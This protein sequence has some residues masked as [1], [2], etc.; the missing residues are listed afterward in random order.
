MKLNAKQTPI[1]LILI[2]ALVGM[3][4]VANAFYDPGLQRWINRDPIWEEG[5]V[6]LYA[7]TGNEPVNGVD[8]LGLWNTCGHNSLLNSA[9]GKNESLKDDLKQWK[10]ASKDMDKKRGA[11]NPENS[12]QHGM[13][14]P[15]K[16]KSDERQRASDFIND[17]L[18]KAI[19]A[20]RQGD[21]KKAM[22]ELGRGMHTIADRSSP[23]HKGEQ[24]WRGLKNPLFWP[25][26]G[27]HALQ[28]LWPNR[29]QR[30]EVV[31]NL[32]D[33]YQQFQDGCYYQWRE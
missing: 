14:D 21:H 9:F 22:D 33:Y 17:Q 6:N 11:Q 19:T 25:H 15:V 23:A 16:N 7:P 10:N 3:V 20:E 2:A 26:A 8:V 32:H 24:E 1:I 29:W 5:G 4:E 13:S 27:V 30:Q 28:E 18:Q 31:D 12:Y